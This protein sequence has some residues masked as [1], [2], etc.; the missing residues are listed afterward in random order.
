MLWFIIGLFIGG[1]VGF[2]TAALCAA[3]SRGSHGNQFIYR[4]RRR[5]K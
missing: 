5:E 2:F 3:A 1:I 4:G